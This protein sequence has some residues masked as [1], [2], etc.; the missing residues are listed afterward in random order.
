MKPKS[1]HRLTWPA[2]AYALAAALGLSACKKSQPDTTPEPGPSASAE[3]V[4]EV[5]AFL[6]DEKAPITPA[7]H[8]KLI[9]GLKD[10]KVNER[11][12]DSKCEGYQTLRKARQRKSA[13]KDNAELNAS[14]GKEFLGHESPAVRLQAAKL[15][16]SALGANKENQALLLDAARKEQVP[17]VLAAM[18]RTVGSRH[19]TTPEVQKLLMEMADHKDPLVRR[20][21]LSWFLTA[22]GEGVE[23]TFNKVLEKLE[24][25]PSLEVRSYLC[26]RLYGSSNERALDVFKKYLTDA[27]TPTKLYNACW[28]G[29]INSWT[30]FPKPR[31][32]SKQGYD[33]TMKIL[34]KTP[35]TGERPPWSGIST[36]RSARTE[37]KPTDRFGQEWLEKV[38][39]WYQPA[40]L[41]GAL[42]AIAT[43]P[44]ANWM[45]RTAALRVMHELGEKEATFVALQKKYTNAKEGDDF[46]VKRQLD[47]I[48][49][50]GAGGPGSASASAGGRVS[51]PPRVVTPGA[52]QPE[53]APT[54]PA[55]PEGS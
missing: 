50:K 53:D 54:P 10:C 45:A 32:P 27:K 36:L 42:K 8:R 23:E 37:Y 31:N 3:A 9:L 2:A 11:G 26:G 47:D 4:D 28:N 51:G 44:Q 24:G 30:G 1:I 52:T 38:K 55:A 14:L 19:R 7:I 39:P 13:A 33:L 49:R 35:R 12:I 43:D 21:A 5:S 48:L 34:E 40:R 18:L 17:A 25:D 22:F 46:H 20:E 6:A 29:V 15:M 16:Q 41:L